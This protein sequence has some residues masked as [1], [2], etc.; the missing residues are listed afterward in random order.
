[1]YFYPSALCILHPAFAFLMP[2]G[3]T[4]VGGG[5]GGSSTAKKRKTSNQSSTTTTAKSSS[6]KLSTQ[7]KKKSA[8]PKDSPDS[9]AHGTRSRKL[10][11]TNL[12]EVIEERNRRH[13]SSSEDD[14]SRDLLAETQE[15]PSSLPPLQPPSLH[16]QPV[17]STQMDLDAISTNSGHIIRGASP[18]FS[19]SSI[20]DHD[21]DEDEFMGTDNVFGAHDTA[22]DMS[23]EERPFLDRLRHFMRGHCISE[24]NRKSVEIAILC[25]ANK[26]LTEGGQMDQDE[27][28]KYVLNTYVSLV[29]AI[30]DEDFVSSN[31]KTVMMKRRKLAQEDLNGKNLRRQYSE[32]RKEMRKTFAN[33]P[34]DFSSIPSGKQLYAIVEKH[35]CEIYADA[36]V[37]QVDS[38]CFASCVLVTY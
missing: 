1:M 10:K 16:A 31:V 8:P 27:Q 30:P 11:S 6:N 29:Q 17:D 2:L 7:R 34:V 13:Y 22:F 23:M 12:L 15:V 18:T 9:V 36:N 38:G 4:S 28:D 21:E 32:F 3:V 14:G 5:G 25:E 26:A 37:S 35:I 33:L 20:N 24:D 19:S